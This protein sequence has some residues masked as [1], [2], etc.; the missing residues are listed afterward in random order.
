VLVPEVPAPRV[1]CP[2]CLSS[3]WFECGC[4]GSQYNRVGENKAGPAP[5]GMDHFR[6]GRRPTATSRSTPAPSSPGRHRHQHHRPGGRGPELH[7]VGAG[8]PLMLALTTTSIAWLIGRRHHGRL[9][10]LRV[11]QRRSAPIRTR[12]RDRTRRQ[13][14][15][16][17]R[18]RDPRGP[19]LERMQLLGVIMLAVIVDR[20]APLLDLRAEPP[21]RG[22]GG[23]PTTCSSS[24]AHSLF[25]PTADGG[26]NCAGCHGGM[27]GVGGVAPFNVTDPLTGEVDA[28]NW[29][30]PAVNTVLYRF[31]ES[32]VRFI[33]V[34]GRP[35]SPMS[36]W[37]VDGG[38]PM[39]DPADRHPDRLHA[40]HPDPARELRRSARTPLTCAI[41]ATCPP[42]SRPTSRQLAMESV[43]DGTYGAYGEALFNLDLGSGAYSCARCHTPGWSWDEPGV[44]GQGA[45]GWNLTGGRAN[46]QFADDD[47]IAFI[48]SGS[49]FGSPVRLRVR[50]AAGCPASVDAH[51]R[52]D[53]GHRRVR[54]EPVTMT[55]V[56]GS[57]LGARAPWPPHGHHRRAWM[58]SRLPHPRYQHGCPTRLPGGAHRARRVDGADGCRVVDLRHRAAAVPTRRGR[59]VAGS[60]VHPGRRPAVSGRCP[61]R[62]ASDDPDEATPPRRAECSAS[63]SSPRDGRII[64]PSAPEFGQA[65][66]AA[67]LSSTRPARS[68]QVS[69]R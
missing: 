12:I 19:R 53:P 11:L 50:A 51:R 69:T 41:R 33:L 14:Q 47:M 24:G 49:E 23:E 26:F 22:A 38:G 36:P 42:R 40:Q 30:A 21:G 9:D 5:R 4:H 44:T 8:R 39:N 57:R 29:K 66:A 67:E 10:P 48:Q 58:G 15:G 63:R 3:Q 20:A 16:V 59:R 65:Q 31:D 6:R 27:N 7:C 55:I 1:P 61:R 37:G 56:V 17:L 68:A 25:A 18:R 13:P 46:T 28:V 64:E 35:F 32:E 62:A 2:E 45:F 43:A 34:Y 52:T 60:T 54:T